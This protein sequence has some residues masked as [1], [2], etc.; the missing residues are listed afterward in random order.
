V[1]E[2]KRYRPSATPSKSILRHRDGNAEARIQAAI[3]EWVP[4]VAPGVLV[5]AVPNGGLRSKSEAAGLK[6][7]GV[8]AGIPD[9][10]VVAQGGRAHFFET[11]RANGQLS[12]DQR[13]IMAILGKFGA[14]F[15]TARSIDDVRRAFDLWGIETCETAPHKPPARGRRRARGGLTM[16]FINTDTRKR[17]PRDEVAIAAHSLDH[18]QARLERAMFSKLH[19]QPIRDR[20]ARIKHE[21]RVAL[22]GAHDVSDPG[23]RPRGT[24]K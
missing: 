11:K 2:A 4:V 19:P 1:S 9:L 24:A 14:P 13:D 18:A 22:T 3:V 15:M 21:V 7:T 8:V 6:W 10:V 20:F 16:S 5:F 23:R 17:A 12:D